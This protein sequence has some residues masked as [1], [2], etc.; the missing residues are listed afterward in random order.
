MSK[1][2]TAQIP[3]QTGRTVVIISHDMALVAGF[4]RRIIA[5]R[6]GEVL[7]DGPPREVFGLVDVLHTTNI[8][9]PQ[10]TVFGTRIGVPGLL[11]VDEA[12]A[13]LA[14]IQAHDPACA[15]SPGRD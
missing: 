2:T 9:P 6:S 10:V 11:D 14:A 13:A 5:M 1:W 4:A 7:A 12:V 15:A 8:R 3:D